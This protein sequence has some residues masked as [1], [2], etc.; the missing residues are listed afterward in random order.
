MSIEY[1]R[2]IRDGIEQGHGMLDPDKREG[3]IQLGRSIYQLTEKKN[4]ERW[5]GNKEERTCP[6]CGAVFVAYTYHRDARCKRCRPKYADIYARRSGP[7]GNTSQDATG[8][9]ETRGRV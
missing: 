7:H 5:S 8:K 3:F 2:L 4:G 1:F 9:Q 6:D